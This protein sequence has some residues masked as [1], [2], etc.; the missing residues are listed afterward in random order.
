LSDSKLTT[1]QVRLHYGYSGDMEQADAFLAEFDRWLENRDAELIKAS[2]EE[3]RK[4]EN[5]RI[6]L[7]LEDFLNAWTKP[8]ALNFRKEIL[9]LIEVIGKTK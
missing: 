1:E 8:V 5:L 9:D 7:L 3:G 2:I 6:T 4:A